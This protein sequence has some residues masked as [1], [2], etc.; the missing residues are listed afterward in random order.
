[1]LLIITFQSRY[2]SENRSEI[3]K[4]AT[5]RKKTLCAKTSNALEMLID[6]FET[7]CIVFCTNCIVLIKPSTQVGS[8]N[9]SVPRTRFA[10]FL[11]KKFAI[12]P[13]FKHG[14]CACQSKILWQLYMAE[15]FEKNFA[16]YEAGFNSRGEF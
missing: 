6:N 5:R 4:V 15:Y 16:N 3:R 2:W 13:F 14:F 10:R 8:K 12:I 7:F 1:M 11:K 9:L